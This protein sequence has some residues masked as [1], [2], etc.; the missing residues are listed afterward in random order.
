MIT[1]TWRQID[2]FMVTL[3]SRLGGVSMETRKSRLRESILSLL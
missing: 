3:M 1:L 2:V